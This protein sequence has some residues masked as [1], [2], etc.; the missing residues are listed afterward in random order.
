MFYI[1]YTIYYILYIYILYISYYILYH[2]IYYILNNI[3]I[4]IPFNAYF[5]VLRS[6]ARHI[7]ITIRSCRDCIP[8][9]EA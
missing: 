7:Y 5:A 8:S 2:M 9:Y 3:Y 1:S 4:Y 6:S